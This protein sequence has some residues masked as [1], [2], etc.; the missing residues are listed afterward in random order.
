MPEAIK[1]ALAAADEGDVVLLSPGCASF[2]M[3]DNFEARGRDFKD[4][5][6]QLTNAAHSDKEN[7]P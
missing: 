4:K 5:L 7:M 3:Y 6:R 2:D 1:Q